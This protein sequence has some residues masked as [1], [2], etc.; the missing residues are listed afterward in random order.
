M[1]QHLPD[2][3]RGEMIPLARQLVGLPDKFPNEFDDETYDLLVK[4]ALVIKMA[5]D[6]LTGVPVRTGL[7]LN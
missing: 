1:P 4:A 2:E 7:H 6:D 5:H 3:L